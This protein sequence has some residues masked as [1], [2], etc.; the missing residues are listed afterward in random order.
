MVCCKS[1]EQ[2]GSHDNAVVVVNSDKT[3]NK[4]AKGTNCIVVDG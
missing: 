2:I 1:N 4:I 3:I